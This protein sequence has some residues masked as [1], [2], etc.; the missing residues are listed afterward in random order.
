M[1]TKIILFLTFVVCFLGTNLTAQTVSGVPSNTGCQNNG[2][3]TASS[4]DPTV[5]IN[6]IKIASIA[7]P[8]R[9]GLSCTQAIRLYIE[10]GF[11]YTASGS[12]V[13]AADAAL[14]RWKIKYKGQLYGKDING[15]GYADV[16]GDGFLLTDA[17]PIMPLNAD[18]ASV[19]GDLANMRV[20][21]MDMCGGSKEFVVTNYN[22][23]YSNITLRNCGGTAII[24]SSIGAGL[25][26]LPVNVTF[27][28]ET[29]PSDVHNFTVTSN[30]QTFTDV[31]TPGANYLVTYKDAEGYTSDLFNA[32]SN[33][34]L[35]TASPTFTA[36]QSV[37]AYTVSL[38]DLDYGYLY[39]SLN[40]SQ[41]TDILTYKVTSSSNPLVP[42]GYTYSAALGTFTNGNTGVPLLPSPNVNAPQP[43]WPKGNYTLQVNSDCGS[44]T[45]NVV[46]QGRTASLS[47]H[48]ITS[49]CGG[50]NYVMNGKFD[51]VSA[52]QVIIVSGP[53][54]VG[55]VRDLASTTAS[56]PFDGL[57]YG[58]YVFGLRIK[59]GTTNVLT[60]T[61]T[62][63]ANNA[64]IVDKTNTG[65]YVCVSGAKTGVLTIEAISNS[66]A[67]G[68][69]LE[70][71]LSTDGGSTYGDYQ[72][73]NKFG[74]LT[75]A[76]YF[77]RIKDDCG[78]I[79]TQSS[80]I[81]VA[82]APNATVNGLLSPATVCYANEGT[83]ELDV[84]A[85]GAISYLWKGPGIDASNQ[86][87]KSPVISYSDLAVGANNYSCSVNMGAPC[88]A[89][90]TA[91]LVIN[92]NA[93]PNINVT[94]PAQVCAPSTV[95][96]TA[97]SIT[98]GSETGLTYTY[99]ED[100]MATIPVTNPNAIAVSNTYYIKATNAMGCSAIA[101]VV[102]S[103]NPLS[104]VTISYLGGS[105]CKTGKISVEKLGADGGTY[106]SDAG[107][108]IDPVSGEINLETS[109]I[110]DHTITYSFSEGSCSG[111]TAMTLITINALPTATIAYPNTAY[112]NRGTASVVK[113]GILNGSFS[114]DAGLSINASTGEIDLAN[115]SS[116]IHTISYAF[117][118]GTCSN[119]TTTTIKISDTVLPVLADMNAECSVMPKMPTITDECAG[120][121]TGTT[122]TLF[123]ITAQGTTV[124]T[125][126]F[127][128]GNGYTK[129]VNQNV[130]ITPIALVGSESAICLDDISGYKVSLS[131]T[132]EG[133]YTVTGTGA[134][135]IWS[136]NTWTSSTIASGSNYDLH[137]QGPS[138]CNT[139]DVAGNAPNCCVFNVVC[140][141]FV[142]TTVSCYSD[143]PSETTLTE[144]Q[145]EALG[146]GDGN[147]TNG[148]CGVIQITASNG[149]D[150]GCN[151]SITRTYTITEYEDANG[152]GL[153]DAGEDTVL[154]TDTCNQ[155]IL[156]HDTKA[157]VFNEPLPEAVI[158]ADCNTIPNAVTLTASDNCG[159]AT[160]TYTETRLDGD[161][162]SKY[163][164]VR[165]WIAADN[166]GNQ[167]TFTQTV[168][169][170]CLMNIY[171]A[172]SPNGDG[173]NDV[174]K[175]EG[176]NCFPNNTV[177][178]Y[179]RYGV[180][181][182]E[183]KG[184]DNVTNPFE[185]F[186]DG[187]ATVARKDKLPTGTYFYIIEY[188]DNGNHT[189][190]SGYL[191][192]NNQ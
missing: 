60:E 137:I 112:C 157:P 189:N 87:M 111:N 72:S 85:F 53:S 145:F 90:T 116:G 131:V 98:A 58:T 39:L 13:S 63:D 99:F 41:P 79:I 78:N 133:P 15:D 69:V 129:T 24:K 108:S 84:D 172:I 122:T 114:S 102:V 169:V 71:A 171:N 155:I 103:I 141:T 101:P 175:I 45:T 140:P 74:G 119:I 180:I 97:G 62:Y 7:Y 164:L 66:P 161:C 178:I 21:L 9:A 81:G 22:T 124:V 50:F 61:V 80:Q 126:T 162:E 163:S 121:I 150:Q 153:R 23:V 65:G 44:A 32:A 123:P 93:L 2:I 47:G 192:I 91:N 135:G 190:K 16:G 42:V 29:N 174:F 83:L 187:R 100:K 55:Q 96:I 170:I 46:V 70:Y 125:W 43:F 106:T 20:V 159:S 30:S 73:S 95:D 132:G 154:N 168:N 68:N 120:T 173:K 186:S 56:N 188:G 128:Y 36:V 104:V 8:G 185:G 27:T 177:R 156:V 28:N 166:C 110:G 33:K 151:S 191:Y 6:D 138:T 94:N 134:P 3:V 31:L 143:L 118:N 5:T 147:I 49:I 107:L 146:N 176:I 64:I 105:F 182:Y 148:Q 10:K 26:C 54:S 142:P 48:T 158:T 76:T 67:P 89:T 18:R 59:G 160:V 149:P 19:V 86:N 165:N 52:Y 139:L 184:Y 82:A 17:T 4:T 75:D 38:N 183:K 117:T 57:S 179:N 130:T 12:L 115:S 25:D 181:V 35:F 92:V 152:N 144:A 113:T 14:F 34:L 51:D 40:P 77:F 109:A 136:G 127:D 11:V 88:N 167:T 1:K 37:T